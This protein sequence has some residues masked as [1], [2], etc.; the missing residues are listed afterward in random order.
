MDAVQH[1]LLKKDFDETKKVAMISVEMASKEE[2]PISVMMEMLSLEMVV[3][4]DA[5]TFQG[6]PV[7]Q[8]SRPLELRIVI[9]KIGILTHEKITTV[10]M[11]MVVVIPVKSS[12]PINEKKEIP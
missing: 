3:T 5:N 12:T 1:D 9:Q 7:Q 10:L 6:L 4:I 8:P 2:A 11:E